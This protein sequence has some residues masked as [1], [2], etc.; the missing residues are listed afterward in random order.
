MLS[1]T[2]LDH[3]EGA[4]HLF[5]VADQ[6]LVGNPAD[7]IGYGAAHITIPHAED[8]RHRQCEVADA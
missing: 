4:L 6:I 7:N 8:R 1:R 5:R 3:A 2:S